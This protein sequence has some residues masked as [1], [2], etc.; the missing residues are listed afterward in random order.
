MEIGGG[1]SRG[2]A[3]N[4]DKQDGLSRMGKASLGM[5]SGVFFEGNLPIGS[6]GMKS[7]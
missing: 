7:F 4:C 3:V 1:R 2:L 5:G 6:F